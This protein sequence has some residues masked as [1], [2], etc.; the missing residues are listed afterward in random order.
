MRQVLGWCADGTLKP[1]VQEVMPLDET[2][3]AL[4]MIES[5]K[6]V[7]KIVVRP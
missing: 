2:I 6:A 4:K 5:R 7:G 1:Y 3:R